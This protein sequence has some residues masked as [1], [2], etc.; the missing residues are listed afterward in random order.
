M[1]SAT[2]LWAV[3]GL[4]LA[5]AT[6]PGLTAEPKR[7]VPLRP[8][9]VTKAAP[10]KATA[11]GTPATARKSKIGFNAQ[12]RPILSNSCFA[13]H[14]PDEKKRSAGLRLDTREGA[15]AESD[16]SAAI[17]PGKPEKSVLIERVLA[18][19]PEERMPPAESKKPSLTADQIALLRQWIAEGADY[20]PHWAFAPLKDAKPPTVRN[21]RWVRNS[22]DN[23]ILARLEKE[24]IQPAAEA[25]R[26]TLIRR[27]YLDLTGLLPSPAEVRTFVADRRPNAY[28]IIVE[29]LLKSPH[30][31]ERWGRHWLDQARY[32]DS[33]GYTF[34]NERTMWPYRDWVIKVL[35]SD[36][37]FDQF[38]IE[39]LAGDLLPNAQ[40]SQLIATAFHR[41]TG[42]NEEGGTNAE[43]FRNEAV[44]DRTN[45]TSTVWLGLTTGCAQCH[46]HKFDPITHRE[47][48]EMFAFFNHTEDANNRGPTVQVAKGEVFGQT[49][50]AETVLAAQQA[51]WEKQELARLTAPVAEGSPVQWAPAQYAEYDTE[52]NAGFKLLPDNSLLSDGRGG[53]N[54]TYRVVAKS[55]LEKVVALRLRVLPHESLPKNGP[56]TAANGN[57]VLTAIE[58][59]LD[60]KPV[61]IAS[62][63]ADHEQPGYPAA[64]ALDG[65]DNTGWA[66]NAPPGSKVKVNSEHEAIF[67][68][69]QPIVPNGKA[70]QVRLKHE[71]NDHYLI[72][73]FNLAFCATTPPPPISE[74][75]EALLNALRAAPEQRTAA[76]LTT[77]RDA[78]LPNPP[79]ANTVELMVMKERAQPRQTFVL[80]RGDFL[81]PDNKVGPLQP[82]VLRVL[83]PLKAQGNGN[84]TRLDLARWL[85]REDNPLTPRVTVNRI[86]MRYFGQ[87]L[88]ETD[89]D[90]GSQGSQ[91]THPELLDWLGREFIR[92]KWSLKA[93]HRLITTSATYR[94]SSKIRP[95]LYEKDPLNRLLARQGRLRVEAE[96]VRDAALSASGLLS[97]TI[98]GPSVRPP[99]PAGVYAFTQAKKNWTPSEGPDRYRRALYTLFYRSAPYPLLGTFDSPDFQT[100]CTRRPRSNTPLQ[101]LTLANDPAFLEIT[102]GLAARVLREVPEKAESQTKATKIEV[103]KETT[104]GAAVLLDRRLKHTFFLCQSRS[105][106]AKELSILRGYYSRQYRL[107]STRADDA[108]ALLSPELKHHNHA[109]AAALVCAAR[110]ILNTDAF[111]T[112]E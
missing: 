89:D 30:Y 67:Y 93:M 29:G 28:E 2:P 53:S 16:G 86:W 91:P 61:K 39:Q 90:F 100:T 45:T 80:Q 9:A 71:L 64:A 31:G 74:A 42:I 22:I 7:Y 62:A 78:Y 104:S 23:F 19:D 3:L 27:V 112:R 44:I 35:N 52:N 99:Q 108:A 83:P 59:T 54:D 33:N 36:M 84:A 79:Q 6:L 1:H 87:G 73:R 21:T 96:I 49:R 106:S 69:E 102:Q 13:C 15:I 94:Q 14:G 107:F 98:G 103:A 10:H 5:G 37:P 12:I 81:R 26:A 32:A 77:I 46:T 95:E 8:Q 72:G 4:V 82:N 88:V 65:K 43:Q 110:A 17:V 50:P 92:N 47:Y 76:Q 60:G 70:L 41:N 109:T 55:T 85:V 66:I 57:F 97:P 18:H 56:G 75:T 20:E 63:R 25:D 24:Q 51:V 11:G 101:S 68:F 34:D 111:I 58:V 38:T 40:K 48:Y 105:P